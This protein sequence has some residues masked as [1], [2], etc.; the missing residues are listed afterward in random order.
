MDYINIFNKSISVDNTNNML[1]QTVS[2][3]IYTRTIY[4]G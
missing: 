4:N 3:S 2:T 1:S